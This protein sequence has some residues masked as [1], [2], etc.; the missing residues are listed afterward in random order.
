MEQTAQNP[1]STNPLTMDPA[2]LLM[3][4]MEG[5]EGKKEEEHL[6]LDS[7]LWHDI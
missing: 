7:K 6:A 5:K 3:E 4:E 2:V 1:L